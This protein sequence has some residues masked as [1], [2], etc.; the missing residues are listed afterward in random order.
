MSMSAG[1]QLMSVLLALSA[2]AALMYWL[3]DVAK[4]DMERRGQPG[5]VFGSFI[6]WSTPMGLLAWW[7]ARRRY[8][9]L[10]DAPE[11]SDRHSR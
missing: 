3:S 4:K 10:D 2:Y 1:L 5:W 7:E 8:P 6:F 11:K 9:I